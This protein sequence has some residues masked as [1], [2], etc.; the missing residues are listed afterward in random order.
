MIGHDRVITVFL[1]TENCHIRRLLSHG[2]KSV[3]F[4]EKHR[5]PA[6]RVFHMGKHPHPSACGGLEG[7]I[8]S[9]RT[10]IDTFLK[11]VLEK[12]ADFSDQRPF[13]LFCIQLL[14]LHI[15]SSAVANH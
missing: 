15:R 5:R 10:Q 1:N 3:D 4:G 2:L 6:V 9:F 14:P 13:K 11:G 7:K 12:D 8:G